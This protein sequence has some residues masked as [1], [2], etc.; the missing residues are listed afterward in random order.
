MGFEIIDNYINCKTYQ[1]FSRTSDKSTTHLIC[2]EHCY[3]VERALHVIHAD[4]PSAIATDSGADLVADDA[5]F[6]LSRFDGVEDVDE[7]TVHRF[8]D[9]K[10]PEGAVDVDPLVGVHVQ[11]PAIGKKRTFYFISHVADMPQLLR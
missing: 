2:E 6:R 9:V 7:R 10:R 5:L 8:V 3:V 1:Y 4:T 11:Q